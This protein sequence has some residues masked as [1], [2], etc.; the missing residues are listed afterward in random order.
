MIQDIARTFCRGFATHDSGQGVFIREEHAARGGDIFFAEGLTKQEA[1]G[2]Q[3][4]R[5]LI[6]AATNVAGQHFTRSLNGLTTLSNRL[7]AEDSQADPNSHPE[8]V[9]WR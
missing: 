2:A 7:P 3:E 9:G 8:G 1:A 4:G 5:I 6:S